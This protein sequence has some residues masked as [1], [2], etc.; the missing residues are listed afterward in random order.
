MIVYNLGCP[1]DHRFEGW[2]DSAAEYERQSKSKLLSCPL[3]GSEKVSRL[4]HAPYV[5]TGSA[6]R[7]YADPATTPPAGLPQQYAN[8]TAELL[9]NVVEKLLEN[10]VDVGRAFPEEARK[11][12]YKEVPE[13]AIR[14]TASAKEV[15][16]LREEGIQVVSVPVPPHR[17][18]KTH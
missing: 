17:L 5:S 13:R 9:S 16:A 4:A 11:I 14:G 6:P 12:H 18:T 15:D 2:F 8:L 10:T 1:N 7:K 3:C